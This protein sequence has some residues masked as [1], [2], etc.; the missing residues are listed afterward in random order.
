[1]GKACREAKSTREWK[2]HA[3]YT[4]D[5]SEPPLAGVLHKQ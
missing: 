2:Q 4:V 5:A 3:Y 1:M